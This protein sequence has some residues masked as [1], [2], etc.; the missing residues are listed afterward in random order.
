MLLVLSVATL[1]FGF[2]APPPR[3]LIAQQQPRPSLVSTTMAEETLSGTQFVPLRRLNTASKW[4]VVAAQTSAVVSVPRP[5]SLHVCFH[6]L[7]QLVH[8]FALLWLWFGECATSLHHLC[9]VTTASRLHAHCRLQP[10][11]LPLPFRSYGA[12]S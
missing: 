7:S 6:A 10:T 11:M 1:T 2:S 12:T 8:T 5:R 4:L 9:A 3:P